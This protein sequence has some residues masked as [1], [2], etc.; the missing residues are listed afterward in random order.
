MSDIA[1][2]MIRLVVYHQAQDLFVLS[3]DIKKNTS[4]SHI[5]LGRVSTTRCEFLDKRQRVIHAFICHVASV[6]PSLGSP[7]AALS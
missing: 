1:T 2:A 3:L 6:A 7:A 4:Y 5:K